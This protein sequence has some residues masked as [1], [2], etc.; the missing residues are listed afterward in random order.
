MYWI[1][2]SNALQK[3]CWSIVFSIFWCMAKSNYQ[4][5]NSNLKRSDFINISST[6][7]PTI[8]NRTGKL[9]SI[10][11]TLLLKLC[12]IYNI[13][14]ARLISLTSRVYYV[15]EKLSHIKNHPYLDNC[16]A[17]IL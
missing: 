11:L 12:N 17:T 16:Y 2:S 3:R 9:Y 15:W 5:R 10:I 13:Q 8:E 4:G 1:N 14:I 7:Q 6:V